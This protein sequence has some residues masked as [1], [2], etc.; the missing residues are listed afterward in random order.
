[1]LLG[2][3]TRCFSSSLILSSKRIPF[4]RFYP[5]HYAPFASDFVGLKNLEI[6]FKLGV[7]FNPFDQLMGVLPAARLLLI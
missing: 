5:H 3:K 7:P 6:Q 1:M 2:S 4:F